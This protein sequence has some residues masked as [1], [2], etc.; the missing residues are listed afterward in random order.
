MGLRVTGGWNTLQLLLWLT[1]MR[2][3]T[4]AV[5]SFYDNNETYSILL[6]CGRS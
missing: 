2:I 6:E 3:E 4:C 1:R 5:C